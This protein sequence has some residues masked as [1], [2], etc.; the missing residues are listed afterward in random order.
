MAF[1]EFISNFRTEYLDI[2]FRYISYLGEITILLPILCILYWCI[3]KQ[4]A[5]KA[6]FAFFFSGSV[7]QGAKITFRIP[8]PW[9]LN[10]D[11][12]PV[13]SALETATG[14]SFPSGHTQSSSS[15]FLTFATCTGHKFISVFSYI[16][17]AL[18]LL[19]RMYLGVHTPLDV[20]TSLAVSVVIVLLL[21]NFTRNYSFPHSN[22]VGLLIIAL[23]YSAGLTL[24]S[25]LLIRW[26]ISTM[27]LVSDA[28]VFSCSLAGFAI[29]AYIENRFIKFGTECLSIFTQIIKVILGIGGMLLI[30]YAFSLIPASEI[31]IDSA[32]SFV[33]CIWATCIF[34]LFIRLVQKKKYSEL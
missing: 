27:E 3:N 29:G 23:A 11:F 5:Y 20:F 16:I 4:L 32:T 18:V 15:V 17:V 8:R 25:L 9:V 31:I 7:I 34:P 33:A 21:R 14:Y 6:L 22:K 10:P 24:Y 19:S 12:A 13:D 26:N 2:F 30:K 1:L 28:I